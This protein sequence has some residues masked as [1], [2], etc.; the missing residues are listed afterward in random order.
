MD[1]TSIRGLDTSDVTQFEIRTSDGKA[2]A[3]GGNIIIDS[4]SIRFIG[5]NTFI[6]F[7]NPV[8]TIF[9]SFS[10]S[11]VGVTDTLEI[12]GFDEIQFPDAARLGVGGQASVGEIRIFSTATADIVADSQTDSKLLARLVLI[13]GGNPQKSFKIANEPEVDAFEVLTGNHFLRFINPSLFSETTIDKNGNWAF[14]SRYT[15]NGQDVI[16]ISNR[17][18]APTNNPSGGGTLYVESGALKYRGSSGTVTTIANA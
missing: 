4:T 12:S 13:N 3:G 5:A 16:W 14:Y 11:R 7:E 6:N 17:T 15:G 2:L 10:A 8:N 9:A 18:T 1:T